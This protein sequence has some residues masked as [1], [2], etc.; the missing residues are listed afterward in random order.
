MHRETPRP[1]PPSI[2][3]PP[4]QKSNASCNGDGDQN[5]DDALDVLDVILDG[6]H[7]LDKVCDR[8]MYPFAS[9]VVRGDDDGARFPNR[10]TAAPATGGGAEGLNNDDV[11]P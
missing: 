10:G 2:S 9:T 4:P 5:P 11:G 6:V 1:P 8:C 3:R 7:I